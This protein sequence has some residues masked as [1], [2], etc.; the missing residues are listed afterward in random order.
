MAGERP[1]RDVESDRVRSPLRTAVTLYSIFVAMFLAIGGVL[2][3]VAP[4][5][6]DAAVRHG[7]ST[8]ASQGATVR[9]PGDGADDCTSAREDNH[10]Y[11]D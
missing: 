11:S 1:N 5:D 7:A 3:L 9:D 10:A 4:A 6:V 8:E 2:R